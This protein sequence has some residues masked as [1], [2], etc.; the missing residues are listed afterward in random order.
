MNDF[1]NPSKVID[2]ISLKEEMNIAD[3]GCGSG[4]WIIPLAKKIKSG[5]IYA[6]DILWE[7]LSA[8]KSVTEI[9]RVYNV[10]VIRC[11]IER[12]VDLRDDFL[13]LVIMSNLLFQV[14]DKDAVI[15]EAERVL[16]KGGNL[17]VV[18]WR[19]KEDNAEEIINNKVKTNNFIFIKEINAGKEH[20]AKLYEKI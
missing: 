1:L 18:D 20:F 19:L 15:K 13:D 4:G 17:L 12:G 3:F 11:D 7:A 8:L 16:R 5:R 9:E 10:R 14:D 2:E 6:I